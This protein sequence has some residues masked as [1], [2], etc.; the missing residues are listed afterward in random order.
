[1]LWH[2]EVGADPALFQALVEEARRYAAE[3]VS[4]RA[5]AGG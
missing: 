1:V 4:L 2:P 5:A 3:R